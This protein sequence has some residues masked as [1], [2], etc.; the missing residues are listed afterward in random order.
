MHVWHIMIVFVSPSTF[1]LLLM[2]NYSMTTKPKQC[3][4]N[5]VADDIFSMREAF[6]QQS[7]L[8]LSIYHKPTVLLVRVENGRQIWL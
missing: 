2:L 8:L 4:K 1:N 6:L 5:L 3:R 7:C